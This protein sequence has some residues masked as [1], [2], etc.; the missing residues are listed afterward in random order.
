MYPWALS[1][2][3]ITRFINLAAK[4]IFLHNHHKSF[5]GNSNACNRWLLRG[6]ASFGEEGHCPLLETDFTGYD[7]DSIHGIDSWQECG[8]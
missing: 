5:P 2:K 7:L 6:G 4:H 1:L 3:E 8:K